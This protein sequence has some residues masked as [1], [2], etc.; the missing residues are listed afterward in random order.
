MKLLI[1]AAM[2]TT[3]LTLLSLLLLLFS[4]VFVVIV[5]AQDYAEGARRNTLI[6]TRTA[7]D[8]SISSLL[9][10]LNITEDERTQE[11]CEFD[12]GLLTIGHPM[13]LNPL[14]KWF[15]ICNLFQKGY[16]LMID[17]INSFPRCGLRVQGKNYGLI[18]KS[19]ESDGSQ[20]KAAAIA[21]SIESTTD[22]FLAPYTS[23]ISNVRYNYIVIVVVVVY[24]SFFSSTF[25]ASLHS[26]TQLTPCLPRR[27]FTF[28]L[29]TIQY[30][31]I[32]NN[33]IN[34]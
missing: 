25:S 16:E 28:S 15:S 11:S 23:S 20:W 33:E 4:T 30:N 32:Q 21:K 5:V 12:G 26:L 22:F 6:L 8:G 34:K 17:S 1:P 13:D 18:L 19:Y 31:T 14:D 29:N 7:D 3:T 27:S 2:L 24:V 9:D 10:P